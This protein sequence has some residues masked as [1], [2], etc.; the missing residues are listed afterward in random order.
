MFVLNNNVCN[1]QLIMFV[2]NNNV[3][4]NINNV[5]NKYTENNVCNNLWEIENNKC[6]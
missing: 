2:I 6:L 5:C 1:N 4:D 3:Y